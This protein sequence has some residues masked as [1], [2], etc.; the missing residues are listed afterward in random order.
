MGWV[1]PRRSMRTL[2]L[3]PIRSALLLS[4][5][6]CLERCLPLSQRGFAGDLR[7]AYSEV[8]LAVKVSSL[9]SST[10][11]VTQMLCWE[12]GRAEACILC[13]LRQFTK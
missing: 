1:L 10:N 11:N 6:A 3:G 4:P 2:G 5:A 13:F 8:L 9:A 12:E 7:A